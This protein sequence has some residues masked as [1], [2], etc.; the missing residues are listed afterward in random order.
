MGAAGAGRRRGGDG[1]GHI[2]N[3]VT[4]DSCR[5]AFVVG[6]VWV[7]VLMKNLYLSD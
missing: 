5:Q 1:I 6:S 2:S 3:G 7:V 4:N